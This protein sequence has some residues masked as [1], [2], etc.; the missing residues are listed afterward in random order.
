M[1]FCVACSVCV[2]DLCVFVHMCMRTCTCMRRETGKGWIGEN[3][4]KRKE[5][6]MC[7]YMYVYVYNICVCACDRSWLCTEQNRPHIVPNLIERH[8][9]ADAMTIYEQVT[10][11]MFGRAAKQQQQGPGKHPPS[12]R[13]TTS[14]RMNVEAHTHTHTHIYVAHTARQDITQ[15]P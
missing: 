2:V 6:M 12:A 7:V 10:A 4:K 11:D 8:N 15:A 14:E 13:I 1:L 5:K 3:E 9:L